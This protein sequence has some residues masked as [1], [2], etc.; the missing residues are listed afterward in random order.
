MPLS[1]RPIVFGIFGSMYAIASVAGPLMGGAFA[2]RITWRLCFYINLP[3]GL[4]TALCILFFFKSPNRELD[5]SLTLKAKLRKL[6]LLGVLIFIPAI[7]CVLLALQWG[8]SKYSWSN[9]RIIVLLVLF[10][11][12]MMSFVALQWWE[13]EKA[14]VPSSIIKQRTLW[15][16]SWFSFFIFGSLIATL[17]YIPL[18]FQAVRG[19][20][21]IRSGIDNLPLILPTTFVSLIAGALVVISGY[22]TWACILSSVVMSVGA[23]LLTTFKTN[24]GSPHWIGYQFVY[25]AGVG[26]GLQQP[27]T[28]VQAALPQEQVP[29]GTAIV[30]FMQTFGGALFVSIAQ[31]VFSNKLLAN[32][33]AQ[34]IP[35]NPSRL[36]QAGAT[37]LVGL[38]AAKDLD[39]LKL[40]YNNTVTQTFYVPVAASA[41]SL[42][43]AVLVPWLSVK[44]PETKEPEKSK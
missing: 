22:Y 13:G 33:S 19:D 4:V 2:D 36:L 28:A 9:A 20:S 40:A 25:G 42:F 23:G 26:L 1:K 39:K 37:S 43:G 7:V 8:G 35:L 41:L 15:S 6:D 21:P 31:N 29:V 44:K 11:L 5:S 24:T 16:T 14:T 34:N 38:V 3:F 18:W 27:L 12:L 30:I 32:V 10:G 17:Y